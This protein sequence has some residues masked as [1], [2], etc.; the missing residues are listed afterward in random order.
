MS[1][2]KRTRLEKKPDLSTLLVA[3]AQSESEATGLSSVLYYG[4]S[5][6]SES[7]VKQIERVW[8]R[9]NTATRRKLMRALVEVGE[10]N[11]EMDYSAIG[12]LGLNDE[13]ASVREAAIDV[14]WEHE[15]IA[16]MD[17]LIALARTDKARSVRASAASALGR[18]VL[19]GELG[20]LDSAAFT[21]VQTAVLDILFDDEEDIDVRRRALEAIAN[22]SN[23]VVSEAIEDAYR[24]NDRRL[25]VSAL[26]AMGRTCDQRWETIVL[27]ELENPDPE[28]RYEAARAAGELELEEAVLPLSRLAFDRDVEIRD[29]AI[30]ALGEIGGKEA[31]RVL[32]VLERDAHA[33]NN[34]DLLTAVKDAIHT[35]QLGS[36][37]FYLMNIPPDDESK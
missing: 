12:M 36:G 17:R 9:L 34:R 1:A 26:F 33:S 25:Q 35:A 15:S 19:S 11:F 10:T 37:N 20:D 23:E 32:T 2:S 24:S 6:L 27:R 31:L 28:M 14:L 3:L 5:D 8:T 22:C 21:R 30:W 13:D 18:F 4:L 29:V 16:L 7:E